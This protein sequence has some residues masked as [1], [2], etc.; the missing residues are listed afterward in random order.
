MKVVNHDSVF[1]VIVHA[2]DHAT[3]AGAV[4]LSK[5][6][7]MDQ[8]DGT[9]QFPNETVP[10][11]ARARRQTLMLGDFFTH[12]RGVLACGACVVAS[13]IY[14][15]AGAASGIRLTRSRLDGIG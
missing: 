10:L 15:G 3:A 8:M 13:A 14:A 12:D 5:A 4:K 9:S 2:E 6:A 7:A 11:G 1:R